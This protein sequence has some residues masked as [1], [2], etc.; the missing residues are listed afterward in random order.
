M[1]SQGASQ[2]EDRE[3]DWVVVVGGRADG[4]DWWRFERGIKVNLRP[5]LGAVSGLGAQALGPVPAVEHARGP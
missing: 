3:V 2:S 5:G 4:G 1:Q